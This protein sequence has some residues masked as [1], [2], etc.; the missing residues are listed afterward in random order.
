MG[1]NYHYYCT[2]PEQP[3]APRSAVR[4][5]QDT[6]AQQP[7]G[8][9]NGTEAGTQAHRSTWERAAC[10]GEG[11]RLPILAGGTKPPG[12]QAPKPLLRRENLAEVSYPSKH[13]FAEWADGQAAT[14]QGFIINFWVFHGIP[15]IMKYFERV[16]GGCFLSNVISH[17]LR[18]QHQ[19]RA[20]RQS[21]SPLHARS[22]TAGHK[23]CCCRRD[24]KREQ[25]ILGGHVEHGKPR[26]QKEFSAL[27][28]HL[29]HHL[30]PLWQCN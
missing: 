27:Q 11:A 2:S 4:L 9:A 13:H 6:L 7:P 30:Y 22:L 28:L 21:S 5:P 14:F 1:F 10:T 17:R 12:L 26:Q 24:V 23:S 8:F 19:A 25:L 29:Q 3:C 16:L 15:Q 20:G 18:S